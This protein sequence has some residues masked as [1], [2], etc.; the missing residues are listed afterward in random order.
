MASNVC[1]ERRSSAYFSEGCAEWVKLRP[2]SLCL[3]DFARQLLSSCILVL[4][5]FA[6]VVLVV[7]GIRITS[8]RLASPH[9]VSP[10][11]ISESSR[12]FVGGCCGARD[13]QCH[14]TR[15]HSRL[16][17]RPPPLLSS[18]PTASSARCRIGDRSGVPLHLASLAVSSLLICATTALPLATPR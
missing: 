10:C 5:N 8:D 13:A 2:L 1:T 12:P 4:P 17:R 6:R 3:V 7:A 15:R 9:I 11:F 14:S 18:S 16:P